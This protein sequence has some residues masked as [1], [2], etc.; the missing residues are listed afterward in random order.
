M[1]KYKLI[2]L[3]VEIYDKFGGAHVSNNN[4]LHCRFIFAGGGEAFQTPQQL[5]AFSSPTPNTTGSSPVKESRRANK[6]NVLF[7]FF[8]MYTG[9]LVVVSSFHIFRH[10]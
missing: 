5:V 9:F 3:T 2:P 8:T 7:M 4:V 10:K 1:N 6:N